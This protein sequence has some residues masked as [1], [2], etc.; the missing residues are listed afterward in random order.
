MGEAKGKRIKAKADRLK[1]KG[2]HMYIITL[3][4]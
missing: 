1:A 4:Q 2:K 3:E